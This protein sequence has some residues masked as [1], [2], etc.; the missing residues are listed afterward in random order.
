MYPQTV[1]RN[2]MTSSFNLKILEVIV[3]ELQLRLRNVRITSND[4]SSEAYYLGLNFK[5]KK[6]VSICYMYKNFKNEQH[7]VIILN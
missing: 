6:M 5:R 2:T 3:L 7:F 4:L 1:R